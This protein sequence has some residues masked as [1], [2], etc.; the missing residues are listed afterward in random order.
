MERLLVATDLG[1]C[2]RVA[3]DR[4]VSGRLD[5]LTGE[6]GGGGGAGGHFEGA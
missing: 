6:T 5:T 2:Q 4:S 1:C 3:R